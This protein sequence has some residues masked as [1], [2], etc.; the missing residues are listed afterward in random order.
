[1]IVYVCVCSRSVG[2]YGY[3]DERNVSSIDVK[4]YDETSSLRLLERADRAQ[5][6]AILS[7]MMPV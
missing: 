5:M 2:I 6:L 1:M 3:T 7:L 4:K